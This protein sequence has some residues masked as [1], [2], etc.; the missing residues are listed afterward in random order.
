MFGERRGDELPPDLGSQAARR[1]RLR[2]LKRELDAERAA[3]EVEQTRQARV[4]EAR[5]RLVEDWA[6]ERRV[7]RE[8]RDWYARE[9]AAR[10]ERG[11]R[12]H[13]KPP[14]FYPQ[15]PP[16]PA[17]KIN[18]TAPDSQLVKSLHGWVQ[19][20]TA[21]AAATPEQLIVAADVI[22]SGNERSRLR[23]MVDQAL[24]ELTGAGIDEQPEVVLADAGYFNTG[25]I[26]QLTARGI[27]PLVSPDASGRKQPGITRRSN[28]FEQ[29][30]QTLQSDEGR[31]LY[32][33]RAQIIE[34]VFAH[35]KILRRAERFQRRGLAACRSEWRLITATHNLLKLWRLTTAP[36]AA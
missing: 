10:A 23:P 29:M 14:L 22:T 1:E 31:D 15:P 21:Q 24:D 30:R 27:R 7:H 5:R 17:G 20:Y 35:T 9:K 13:G 11:R 8:W 32:R 18:V 33:R 34:P 2:E 26:E 12:M 16:A 3:R 6:V 36:A 4:V 25:H 28:A 19:G